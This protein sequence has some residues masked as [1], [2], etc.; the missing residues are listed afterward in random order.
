M[1]ILLTSEPAPSTVPDRVCR[2]NPSLSESQRGDLRSRL[3]PAYS[4]DWLAQEARPVWPTP[5]TEAGREWLRVT[6]PGKEGQATLEKGMG[7]LQ[8]GE[9]HSRYGK[10]HRPVWRCDALR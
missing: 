10:W 9:G 4:R 3:G 8:Q 1:L 6:G 2:E 5:T 7:R